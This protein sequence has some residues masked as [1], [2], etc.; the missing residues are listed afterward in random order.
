MAIALSASSN[1][2]FGRLEQAALHGSNR[3]VA[4]LSSGQILALKAGFK[5]ES[6]TH[7]VKVANEKTAKFVLEAVKLHLGEPAARAAKEALTETL[8]KG[9]HITSRNLTQV[10][11]VAKTVAESGVKA[12][13]GSEIKLSPPPTIPY[14]LTALQGDKAS[15]YHTPATGK[16]KTLTERHA[17]IGRYA[18]HQD[19]KKGVEPGFVGYKRFAEADFNKLLDPNHK[20][21]IRAAEFILRELKQEDSASYKATEKLLDSMEKGSAK[22]RIADFQT[23]LEA[24]V[25]LGNEEAP[26]GARAQEL[27]MALK[28]DLPGAKGAEGP[29]YVGVLIQDYVQIKEPQYNTPHY[30]KLDYKEG[31]IREGFSGRKMVQIPKER[32]KG[33]LHRFFTGKTPKVAN[34]GAVREC[35]AN[36]M[37]RTM[38]IYTQ[39]LKIIASEYDDGTPKLLLDG[40]HMK[41]PKGE[42]FSDF[43]GKIKDGYLVDAAGQ[44]DQSIDSLGKYLITFLLFGDR[45]AIGSRGDNKG[46][47][48]NTFAAIDPGHS[49]EV[50]GGLLNEDL[51]AFKNINA[52]FSFEQPTKLGDKVSKGYKNFSI[53]QDRPYAEKF[54]GVIEL[55]KLR[56]LGQDLELFDAYLR[57]FA[58]GEMDFSEPL[59]A[60]RQA[61]INRRDYIL[62]EVFAERLAVYYADPIEGPAAVEFADTL[63]KLTSETSGF[64][65][66]KTVKLEYPRVTKRLPWTVRFDAITNNYVFETKSKDPKVLDKVKKFIDSQNQATGIKA[67]QGS[68]GLSMIVPADRI[69]EVQS[70]CNVQKIQSFEA[71]VL[72]AAYERTKR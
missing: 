1:S 43:S 48:G 37:M 10:L 7:S 60:I 67:K 52:D 58:E 65:P 35:L 57:Q 42:G 21:S 68:T 19:K 16:R 38:G 18:F 2:P 66:N 36:D 12:T 51:M 25:K 64:S 46:R 34:F 69:T 41:G 47:V 62:D 33:F 72:H 49:F 23:D 26:L 8:S 27:F 5:P 6:L 59:Q 54:Q 63:E 44:S 39:K 13:K 40:A 53:F 28:Q 4:D 17:S 56:A 32:A 55:R 50:G 45:D 70:Q 9:T 3:I 24:Y 71:T 29:V 15:I 30:V 31:D 22:V 11:T 14:G 20:F 61:Y